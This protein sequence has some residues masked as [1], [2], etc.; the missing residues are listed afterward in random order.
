MR[1]DH[2]RFGRRERRRSWAR[3][4][5]GRAWCS[6]ALDSEDVRMTDTARLDTD[7]DLPRRRD[8][9]FPLNHFQATGLA[10]LNGAIGLCHR[11]L[12]RFENVLL[13]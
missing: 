8:R 7:P 5:A 4:H 10:H 1:P 11:Q 13:P 6:L 2:V 12:L 3:S 9:Q